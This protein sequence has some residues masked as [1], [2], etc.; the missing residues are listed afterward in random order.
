MCTCK[1]KTTALT[2]ST[3]LRMYLRD[4]PKII[5]NAGTYINRV[6]LL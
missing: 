1:A 5:I 4:I 6:P 2:R 3:Y